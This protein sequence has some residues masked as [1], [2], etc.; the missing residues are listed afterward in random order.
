MNRADFLRQD[1]PRR[2]GLA[3][4]SV[5]LTLLAL[6]C[7]RGQEPP[8]AAT[9][10]MAAPVASEAESE[11]EAAP[12]EALPDS[13]RSD[14]LRATEPSPAA[15]APEAVVSPPAGPPETPE[16]GKRQQEE[17]SDMDQIMVGAT[18]F[19]K[20]MMHQGALER[21]LAP[22][23][24]SCEGALPRK[25]AICEIATRICELEEAS[26]SSGSQR[27]CEQA[28][29]ACKDAKKSFDARCG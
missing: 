6:G 17:A 3:Q 2:T 10:R 12:N 18:E 7:S 5:A 26:P 1:G 19:D 29:K 21:L 13:G 27:H 20:L 9:E 11:E 16:K 25:D 24:M 4:A 14:E 15:P 8:S 22:E 23:H 28:R